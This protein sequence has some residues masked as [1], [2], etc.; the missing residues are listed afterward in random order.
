MPYSQY[1]W[2]HLEGMGFFRCY[3]M[4]L[5]VFFM[6]PKIKKLTVMAMLVAISVVLV[7]F[8]HFPIFPAAT[9]LEYDPA[10]IPILIG[11]FAYGP[12]AGII[13]TVVASVIQGLTVS[14]HS[15]L[16]GVL[17]HIIATSVLVLVA[18]TI[19]KFKHTKAG[20]VLGLVLGTLL[21]GLTMMVA[22]HFITPYFMGAPVAVVDAMLLPVILP[23]NLI[24]AGVNSIV[25]F[26]VYKAVSRHIIHG[27]DVFAAK[28]K[29]EVCM[30]PDVMGLEEANQSHTRPGD[31]DNGSSPKR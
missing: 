16:Y 4:H 21:M 8:I 26:L 31:A 25:T 14:A 7:Y 15:G 13:L 18:G 1:A 3:Y 30:G 20:A 12:V 28:G 22:N 24:K 6:N 2:K 19:Y 10:D 11:A 17:M 9:F 29:P 5:G 27:E 23:F